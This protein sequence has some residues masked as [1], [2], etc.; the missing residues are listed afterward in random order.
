MGIVSQLAQSNRSNGFRTPGRMIRGGYYAA[1]QNELL[2]DMVVSPVSADADIRWSLRTLRARMRDLAIN[3]DYLRKFLWMVTSNVIGP[4]G[5]TLQCKLKDMTG[6]LDRE[7]NKQIEGT[8]LEWGR[9][10][11]CTVTRKQSWPSFQRQVVKTVA[12]DGEVFIRKVIGFPNAFKFALQALEA[13]YVDESYNDRSKN[14]RM[15]IEYD[16]WR[17]PVAYYLLKSNIV[18]YQAD[19]YSRDY[20]RIPADQMIHLFVQERPEQGRGVPWGATTMLRLHMLGGYQF[21][22]VV[23]SRAS[24]GKMGFYENEGDTEYVGDDE[25]KKGEL[26]EEVVPGMIQKLPP[27]MKFTAYDPQHPTTAFDPFVKSCL[28]GISSGLL[29]SYNTLANDLEG[30]NYSSIRQGVLD[31]R[32]I[33]RIIQAWVIDDLCGDVFDTFKVVAAVSGKIDIAFAINEALANSIKWQPRGWSWVDPEKDQNANII[34][35]RAGLNT[36]TR[37]VAE[38]GADLEDLFDELQEEE[39]MAKERGIKIDGE[40][41]QTQKFAMAP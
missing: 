41:Q 15:G 29:V 6:V 9:K 23:A 24:A 31:E 14:I 13:D 16:T 27:K 5:I 39:R 25:T 35:I 32:D 4:K 22:E 2:A 8:F 28:R 10:E 36:R 19:S 37:S 34:G 17:S 33:W 3:N 20:I 38:E 26:I 7:R 12:R 21:N 11:N 40:A 1:S 18:D 30:V